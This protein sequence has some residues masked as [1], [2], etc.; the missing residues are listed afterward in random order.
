[1]LLQKG[2]KISLVCCLFS[3]G[4]YGQTYDKIYE[5]VVAISNVKDFPKP[6]W[7]NFIG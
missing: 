6:H 4:I 5:Q 3:H 2:E 1:M 7:S